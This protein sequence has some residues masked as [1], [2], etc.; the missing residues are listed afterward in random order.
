MEVVGEPHIHD[1]SFLA[2]WDPLQLP[3]GPAAPNPLLAFDESDYMQTFMAF[4]DQTWFM[5]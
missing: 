1:L 2:A 3:P 5:Q 4:P